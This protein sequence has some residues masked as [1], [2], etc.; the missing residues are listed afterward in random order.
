MGFRVIEVTL[1]QCQSCNPRVRDGVLAGGLSPFG[2]ARKTAGRLDRSSEF[3][4]YLI[5]TCCELHK[6]GVLY[7]ENS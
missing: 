7:G 3:C 1:R 4:S 5:E 6:L 2:S